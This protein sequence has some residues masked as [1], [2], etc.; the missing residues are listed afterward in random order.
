MIKYIFNIK[1]QSLNVL[2]D[3]MDILKDEVN[4]LS[5]IK[6]HSTFDFS[7]DNGYIFYPKETQVG[8]IIPKGN[9]LYQVYKS[10][11]KEIVIYVT[12]EDILDLRNKQKVSIKFKT[13]KDEFYLKGKVKYISKF[14]EES[15]NNESFYKVK[16]SL[17]DK[18]PK[19]LEN[20]Y[21]LK[22]TAYVELEKETIAQ[23]LYCKIKE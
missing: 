3:K 2:S 19:Q 1:S 18:I 8:V 13:K 11:E 6:K 9:V 21:Y 7:S 20:I 15:K 14:P 17:E 16:I 23:Y 4:D 12:N 10:K 5:S 22:G